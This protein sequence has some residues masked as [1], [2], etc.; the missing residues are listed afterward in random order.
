[1]PACGEHCCA[2]WHGCCGSH[3]CRDQERFVASFGRLACRGVSIREPSKAFSPT[4]GRPE[5]LS[6]EWPRESNQREGHPGPVA[7]RASCPSSSRSASG[8]ARRYIRVPIEQHA[9]LLCAS[10]RAGPP[11]ARRLAGA[12]SGG[13]PGRSPAS[14]TC[15]RGAEASISP[16]VSPRTLPCSC[17]PTQPAAGARRAC[18]STWM[19]EFA[20]ARGWRVAQG[21]AFAKRALHGPRGAFLLVTSLWRHKE[22]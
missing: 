19:C 15:G 9:H 16:N 20:P 12:P 17:R 3:S 8:V 5:S 22:K 4:C 2:V 13:H 18:S 10:L 21:T 7:L 14:N 1:M 11:A 6:L